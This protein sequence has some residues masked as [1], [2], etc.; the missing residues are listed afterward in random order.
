MG[1]SL[2]A[3]ILVSTAYVSIFALTTGLI[4]PL[5]RAFV[6]DMSELIGLVFLPHGVRVLT[7]FFFGWRGILY[8]L[9]GS[10]AMWALSVYGHG[11]EGLHIAGTLISLISCYMGVALVSHL[12]PSQ[13]ATAN[14]FSWRQIMIAGTVGS[15]ANAAGLSALQHTSPSALIFTGYVMGDVIGLFIVLVILMFSFRTFDKVV[16]SW[17]R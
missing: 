7:F 16:Q 15:V 8:L 3:L 6:P 10:L 2:N 17:R 5:Q 4:A 11:Q 1:F 12:L 14:P 9:P 13:P